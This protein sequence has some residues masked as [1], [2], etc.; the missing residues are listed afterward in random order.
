MTEFKYEAKMEPVGLV[1]ENTGAYSVEQR[2]SFG[3]EG[4]S[5]TGLEVL[6]TTFCIGLFQKVAQELKNEGAS[7]VVMCHDI[8]SALYKVY[9]N[10][11]DNLEK[12]LGIPI[13]K[14]KPPEDVDGIEA[15]GT[16]LKE[17]LA[18][19][20]KEMQVQTEIEDALSGIISLGP[21]NFKTDEELDLLETFK[22][23]NN[24]EDPDE[25]LKV[26]KEVLTKLKEIKKAELH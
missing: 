15:L 14:V 20:D 5:S 18:K 12:S 16:D 17:A 10:I 24:I 25:K 13:V 26:L 6:M 8:S 2:Y 1:N 9:G 19:A 3:D 11:A 22:K 7:S 21:P 23:S 4:I